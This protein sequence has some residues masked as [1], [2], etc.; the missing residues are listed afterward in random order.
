MLQ[1]RTE[2]PGHFSDSDVATQL[3]S[4][5]RDTDTGQPARDDA[6]ERAKIGIDIESE[7]V[8]RRAGGDP[9]PDRG[10]LA[11][12]PPIICRQPDAGPAAD[13][14]RRQPVLGQHGDQRL[15]EP[16]HVIDNEYG[17]RK[18]DDRVADEL[19]RTVPGDL[20]AAVNLN[21]RCAVE[22]RSWGSV[23]LPAV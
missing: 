17:L 12:E 18:P 8:H 3:S 9:D 15:F 7:A 1:V 14:A 19:S 13:S 5:R 6:V 21:H 20:A 10:D 4:H 23:R 11:L 16:S 22:G 2:R